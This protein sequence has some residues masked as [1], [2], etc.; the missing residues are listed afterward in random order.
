MWVRAEEGKHCQLEVG[1][2]TCNDT[3]QL[4]GRSQGFARAPDRASRRY[5]DKLWCD[6]T[7]LVTRAGR[8]CRLLPGYP[9]ALR[10]KS[11][12]DFGVRRSL[13]TLSVQLHATASRPGRI[14]SQASD[15]RS[16][17][18]LDQLP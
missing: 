16:A 15:T 17:I 12:L 7:C 1:A 3:P 6:P 13:Q 11:D 10:A 14:H 8:P 4:G 5:R 2:G 18:L 9:A